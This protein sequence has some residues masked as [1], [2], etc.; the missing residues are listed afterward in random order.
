MVLVVL[1][2]V[3]TQFWKFP[4]LQG[5]VYAFPLVLL[6]RQKPVDTSRNVEVAVALATAGTASAHASGAS[7]ASPTS[8]RLSVFAVLVMVESPSSRARAAPAL[9]KEAGTAGWDTKLADP[10]R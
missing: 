2:P 7:T 8:T 5:R 6:S 10:M 9:D 3:Y 1:R 4:P